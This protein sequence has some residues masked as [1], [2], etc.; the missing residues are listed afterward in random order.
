MTAEELL[1]AI[2]PVVPA[3]IGVGV[4]DWSRMRMLKDDVTEFGWSGSMQLPEVRRLIDNANDVL[5]RIKEEI[6]EVLSEACV[7]I[8]NLDCPENVVARR[9]FE[10]RKKLEAV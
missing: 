1:L 5:G 2:N 4:Q 6:C 8:G 7:E 9:C 3:L 10:L